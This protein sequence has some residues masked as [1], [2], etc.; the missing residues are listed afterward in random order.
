MAAEG[1]SVKSVLKNSSFPALLFDILFFPGV[2][3]SKKTLKKTEEIL[4]C[5]SSSQQVPQENPALSIWYWENYSSFTIIIFAFCCLQSLIIPCNRES[6][7]ADVPAL[8]ITPLLIFIT[9]FLNIF[10]DF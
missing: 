4:R 9:T 5:S 7:V 2:F 8:D 10:V 1:Y 3:F 6:Q